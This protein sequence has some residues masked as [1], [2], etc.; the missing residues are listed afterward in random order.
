MKMNPAE[1]DLKS[2]NAELGKAEAREIITWAHETFG[3]RLAVLSAFQKSGCALCHMI[4]DMNLQNEVDVIFVDTGVNF[5]ETYETIER[6]RQEYGLN[7]ISLHPE[8]TM[9][10]Q[11]EEEGVLY[12]TPEGQKRCC[13]LRKRAPLSQITGKYDALLAS[14][15]R[16]DGGR[17][18][19]TPIALVDEELSLLRVHPLAN[20]GDKAL[21][22][23]L[24]THEVVTNPLHDQGYPTISCDRCTT[25]V[26]EGENK[27][28]GRWRHLEHAPEYCEINPTDRAD[29]AI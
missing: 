7:I 19:T 24:E 12:I 29:Y 6:L 11:T 3:R 21:E 20:M 18:A 17:R 1:L 16:A 13:Y 2:I 5:R 14:L 10:R 28:A 8:R 27:R 25:P 15:R 9:A 4:A 23:Y 22:E 26:L